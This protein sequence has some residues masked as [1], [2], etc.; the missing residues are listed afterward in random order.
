MSIPRNIGKGQRSLSLKYK[1]NNFTIA[2][3]TICY[4]CSC[5]IK[6]NIVAWILVLPLLLSQMYSD[7]NASHTFR[8]HAPLIVPAVAIETKQPVS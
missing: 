4:F 3:L 2:V 5:C 7:C 1:K 6:K 8:V